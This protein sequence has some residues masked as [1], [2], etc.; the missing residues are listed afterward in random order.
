MM[1]G[2]HVVWA[3]SGHSDGEEQQVTRIT[4]GHMIFM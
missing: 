3:V 2:F 4:K 1:N